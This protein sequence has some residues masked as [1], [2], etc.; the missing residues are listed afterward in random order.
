[1]KSI[2]PA[3]VFQHLTLADDP[4]FFFVWLGDLQIYSGLRLL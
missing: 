1:M 2:L 3:A 4:G